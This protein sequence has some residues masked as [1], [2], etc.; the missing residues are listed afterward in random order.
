MDNVD[1]ISGQE[2]QKKKKIE[3]NS[4]STKMQVLFAH[5]HFESYG[6]YIHG[7]LNIAII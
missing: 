5:A 4:I 1:F 2:L 7:H 3:R 6:V